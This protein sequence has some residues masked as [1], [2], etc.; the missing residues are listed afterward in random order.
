MVR[1][2]LHCQRLVRLQHT[3]QWEVQGTVQ[4]LCAFRACCCCYWRLDPCKDAQLP[5]RQERTPAGEKCRAGQV[6]SIRASRALPALLRALAAAASLGRVPHRLQASAQSCRCC[7]C[8]ASPASTFPSAPADPKLAVWSRHAETQS[9]AVQASMLQPEASPGGGRW[10]AMCCGK[11]ERHRCSEVYVQS[12][13]IAEQARHLQ[14]VEVG[15]RQ[16]AHDDSAP[17][18]CVLPCSQKLWQQPA[19]AV[20]AQLALAVRSQSMC[21]QLLRRADCSQLT[22]R[23][24][25]IFAQRARQRTCR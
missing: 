7:P 5:T 23:A 15:W 22:E 4:N 13:F 2:G 20:R 14:G 17:Q 16:L 10:A 25:V 21:C 18:W 8:A 9:C 12:A 3:L 1:R 6:P 19:Q 11:A 24:R